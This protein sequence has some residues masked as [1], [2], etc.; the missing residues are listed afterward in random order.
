MA[1][2]LTVMKGPRALRLLQWITRA[3]TFLP[4]PVSPTRQMVASVSATW[5]TCWSRFC[6]AWLRAIT[7][8]NP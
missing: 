1:A 2:Q 5:A 3:M 6:M 4:V 7:W 8:S